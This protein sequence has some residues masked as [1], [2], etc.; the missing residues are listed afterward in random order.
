MD[1]LFAR[2]GEKTNYDIVFSIPVHE[3]F[4]VVLDQIMNINFYNKNC[5]IIIHLSQVFDYKNSLLSR[6]EFE[7]IVFEIG[8]VYINPD[9]LRTGPFDIIQAHI[10]NF[11]YMYGICNFTFYSMLAS[12]ELFVKTNLLSHISGYDCGIQTN[13]N[14][15]NNME[16]V[17]AACAVMY[18]E[19]LPKILRELN[20][21]DIYGSQIEG[22]FYKRELLFEICNL[23]TKHYDYKGMTFKYAREEIYF[24]TIAMALAEDRKITVME[25]GFFTYVPW[26]NIDDMRY[27]PYFRINS[28]RKENNVFAIKRVDRKLNDPVR[29]FVRKGTYYE[30]E[31]KLI[32][33]QIFSNARLL[34]MEIGKF[35]Q[36]MN[37]AL[38]KKSKQILRLIPS[39]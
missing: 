30:T 6:E 16:W 23:I 36:N 10:S 3:K 26:E 20:S 5:A 15:K 37:H 17:Q 12:N 38:V 29:C 19:D 39:K 4:E 27:V 9:S 28:L 13:R 22:T 8:N 31:R 21:A 34:I 11:Y 32:P 2:D 25:N 33:V 18:D 7:T 35:R 14:A 1:N 24:S